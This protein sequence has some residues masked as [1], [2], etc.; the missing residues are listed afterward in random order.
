MGQCTALQWEVS[1]YSGQQSA[2]RGQVK[3]QSTAGSVEGEKEEDQ[4]A[5]SDMYGIRGLQSRFLRVC[6][7]LF[8]VEPQ[9]EH[10]PASVP[11]ASGCVQSC[12]TLLAKL[13][14]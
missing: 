8:S 13:A 3:E 5:N 7:Y 11:F 4:A 9:E 10:L 14:C 1:L 6:V 12:R 2:C